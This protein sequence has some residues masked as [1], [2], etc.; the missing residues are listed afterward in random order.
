MV[1]LSGLAQKASPTTE[2]EYN[3]CV[4]GYQTMIS[5]GLEMKKGYSIQN[6]ITAGEGNYA[7]SIKIFFRE[8]KKEVAALIIIAKSNVSGNVYYHCIPHDN[9]QL[10]SSYWSDLSD[11]DKP[12]LLSFTKIM[13][14]Y[15]GALIPK[16]VDDEK[17]LRKN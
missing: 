5:G 16:V 8:Q 9:D 17:A 3:Y 11:W 7:F 15:F 13:M 4:K 10:M 12:M 6:Y 1:S 2:E 14:N